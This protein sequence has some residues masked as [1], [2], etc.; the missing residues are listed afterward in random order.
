MMCEGD[1]TAFWCESRR[2]QFV[3]LKQS[4]VERKPGCN[5]IKNLMIRWRSLQCIPRNL[6]F[7]VGQWAANNKHPVLGKLSI[8]E[9]TAMAVCW[10]IKKHV[11]LCNLKSQD[12]SFSS[13]KHSFI[14]TSQGHH[15]YV[16]LSFLRNW[17]SNSM[18]NGPL[19]NY[20]QVKWF[21]E[22]NEVKISMSP[23][24]FWR[25]LSVL[26]HHPCHSS[27]KNVCGS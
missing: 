21:W 11:V 25:V 12:G 13:N 17:S 14:E 4:S 5:E 22:I 27:D 18:S 9:L 20:I 1:G 8:G 24:G 10:V 6:S 2:E 3:S 7:S 23:S 16:S 15:K 26:S 19:T